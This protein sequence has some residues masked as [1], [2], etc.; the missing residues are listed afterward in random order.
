MLIS[1]QNP[2]QLKKS[3]LKVVTRINSTL[4]FDWRDI[5]VIR[6]LALK[7]I[8]YLNILL[9]DIEGNRFLV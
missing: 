9:N 1:D 3:A 7:S 5:K 6:Y 8:S 4:W 2:A